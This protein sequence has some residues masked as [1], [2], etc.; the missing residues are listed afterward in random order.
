M[1]KLLR[2]AVILILVITFAVTGAQ[3]ALAA[4]DPDN[5]RTP[6]KISL[7]TLKILLSHIKI[8][9]KTVE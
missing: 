4:D 2:N 5:E 3:P 7:N 6:T 9:R 1:K 8:Q